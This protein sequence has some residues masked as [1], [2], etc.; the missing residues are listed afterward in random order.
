M[1]VT[2]DPQHPSYFAEADL[3]GELTRIFDLCHGCR[4]CFN[5]CPSFPSMFSAIDGLSLI[6]I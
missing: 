4:L 1:T 6:H 3:R 5:L 2:Y